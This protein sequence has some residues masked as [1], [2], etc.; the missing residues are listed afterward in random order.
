VVLEAWSRR[1]VGWSLDRRPAAAMVN[2]ALGMAVEGRQP[3]AGTLIHSDHG[4]V[5]P[6]SARGPP[7][8]PVG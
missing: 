4:S 6:G 1:V 3:R 2:S 5:S 7:P 8:A